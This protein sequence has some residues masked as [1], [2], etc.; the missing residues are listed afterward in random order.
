MDVCIVCLETNED[1]LS[2]L[3]AGSMEWNKYNVQKV[4]EKHLWWWYF[5]VMDKEINS[6]W[7]CN[8]CW[9]QISSFHKFF[10]RVQK[11]HYFFSSLC[12]KEYGYVTETKPEDEEYATTTKAL[13][14]K[15]CLNEDLVPLAKRRKDVDCATINTSMML[16]KTEEGI[17]MEEQFDMEFNVSTSA[18]I[19]DSEEQNDNKK[20]DNDWQ[21]DESMETSG[22]DIKEI[23][24]YKQRKKYVPKKVRKQKSPAEVSQAK[25]LK[26]YDEFISQNHELSCG[27]CDVSLKDFHHLNI[28]FRSEHNGHNTK[29]YILCCG[30]K[31][32]RRPQFVDHLHLHKDTNYFKC[33]H[34]G[35]VF[36][37]RRCLTTHILFHDED[38]KPAFKCDECGKV[39][40]RKGTLQKHQ[41]IH[42]P[43]EQR[44]FQCTKCQKKF[45]T[46]SLRT[47]HIK[48]IHFYVRLICDTCG[49]SFRDRQCFRRHIAQHNGISIPSF[50][51][52]ICGIKVTSMYGLNR[53]KKYQHT[54]EN[55]QEQICPYCSKVSPNIAA[56]KD[57]IHYSHTMQRKHACHLCEKA[58]KRPKELKEHISTH[59][60]EALYTCPHCPRTFICSANM[61]KHRK[62][63][64]PLE[65]YETRMKRLSSM[66]LPTDVPQQ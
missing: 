47:Q 13:M 15:S 57:H 36:P 64:H 62:N 26:E 52:D 59:T 61:H 6:K 41:L 4:I 20:F 11:S 56:L 45:A 37:N 10:L 23:N 21:N 55:M 54:E 31:F 1:V 49:K 34:C 17:K 50:E 48:E 12:K 38:R 7:I 63:E 18:H 51:C 66:K 9:S 40:L 39:F 2:R 22:D 24:V 44:H 19:D 27:L 33:E 25:L 5:N 58:F 65:W 16:V 43:E 53:H 46:E 30:K 42:V 60:G 14:A 29:P 28:H 32:S 3:K 8:E 35:K